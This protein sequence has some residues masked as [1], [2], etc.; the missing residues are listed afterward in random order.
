MWLDLLILYYSTIFK[1]VF[2]SIA[3]LIN[4]IP[5]LHL[6]MTK[7]A[8]FD[9]D[10]TVLNTMEPFLK[11]LEKELKIDNIP[12][13]VDYQ[14]SNTLKHIKEQIESVPFDDERKLLASLF[15][16]FF[17]SKNANT[18]SLLDEDVLIAFKELEKKGFRIRFITSRPEEIAKDVTLKN[19]KKYGLDIYPVTFAKKEKHVHIP[20]DAK[21][22]ITFDDAPHH[23]EAYEKEDHIIRIYM[24]NAAYNEHIKDSQ[25]VKRIKSYKE[26]LE[27]DFFKDL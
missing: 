15:E 26:V 2:F 25:K 22:V 16:R 23:I 4:A 27:D 19:L 5:H 12:S 14:M 20:K 1:I 24:P 13:P 11:H 8:I 10:D 9:I 17:N 6:T 18:L 3:K 7:Y 21:T